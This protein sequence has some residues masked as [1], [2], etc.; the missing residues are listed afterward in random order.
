MQMSVS[1]SACYGGSE[2]HPED[3][4]AKVAIAVSF[5]ARCDTAEY[6]END[7]AQNRGRKTTKGRGEIA[8][9]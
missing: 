7:G 4:W 8:V 3:V 2:R 5:F 6:A 9:A 1:Q